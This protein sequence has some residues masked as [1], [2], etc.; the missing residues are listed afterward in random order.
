MGLNENIHF[1]GYYDDVSKY[2][3]LVSSIAFIHLSLFEGFGISVAEAMRAAKPVIVHNGTSYPEV[4]GDAGFLVDGTDPDQ[5]AKVMYDIQID[6]EKA[7]EIGLRAR[8]RSLMFDWKKT[9]RET[10]KAL[11]P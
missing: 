7:K 4:V 11:T 1:S 10:M 8:E 2:S 6:K 3:L 5:V 9:A